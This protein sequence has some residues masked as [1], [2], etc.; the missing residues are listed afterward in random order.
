LFSRSFRLALIR[1]F[2]YTTA[3]LIVDLSDTERDILVKL[4]RTNFME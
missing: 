2:P 1:L 4:S 3:A